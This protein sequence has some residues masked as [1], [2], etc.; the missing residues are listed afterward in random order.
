MIDV[1]IRSLL[2]SAGS[3]VLDFYIAHSIP[4]NVVIL[5]YVLLVWLG[6]RSYKRIKADLQSQ[7]SELFGSEISQKSESSLRKALQKR[8]LNWER[9]LRSTAL[10][11]LSTPGAYYFRPKT[12]KALEGI[13]SVSE[14]LTWFQPAEVPADSGNINAQ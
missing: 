13:F 2:G 9:A 5:F 1:M 3:A 4:I 10:P 7:L 11:I 8:P 6:R 14:M 12:Q